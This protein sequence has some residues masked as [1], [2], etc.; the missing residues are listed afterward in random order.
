MH[1]TFDANTDWYTLWMR[2]SKVLSCACYFLALFSKEIA[3]SFPL[4]MGLY[5]Y[6]RV[7]HHK[8]KDFLSEALKRY[9]GIIAVTLFYLWVWAFVFPS[10][11]EKFIFQNQT[12]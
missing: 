11:S 9:A 12:A 2:Q 6:F 5:D 7:Y 10:Q 3:I 4:M 1:T 8:G